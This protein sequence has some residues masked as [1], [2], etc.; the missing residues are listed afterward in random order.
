MTQ[1]VI[2]RKIV[3][4]HNSN[5]LCETVTLATLCCFSSYQNN[6]ETE[7]SLFSFHTELLQFRNFRP[8]FRLL[9]SEL[10][11]VEDIDLDIIDFLFDTIEK[12]KILGS[13]NTLFVTIPNN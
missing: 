3:L 7:I 4:T 11:L 2:S 13:L 8:I 12:S 9:I 10:F 1:M 6:V 5:H